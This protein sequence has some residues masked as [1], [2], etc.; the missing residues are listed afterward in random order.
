MEGPPVSAHLETAPPQTAPMSSDSADVIRQ[1][2]PWLLSPSF[3]HL[4]PVPSDYKAITWSSGVVLSHFA[5]SS[6]LPFDPGHRCL[7]SALHRM[8]AHAAEI[9]TA[10]HQPQA[11]TAS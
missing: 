1:R 5:S 10:C 3:F 4:L 2:A 7:Y 6:L 8:I 11:R 9:A